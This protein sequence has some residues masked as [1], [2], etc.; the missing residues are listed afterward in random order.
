MSDLLKHITE[1]K[2]DGRI[3]EQ[4]ERGY[5]LLANW[6]DAIDEGCQGSRPRNIT[7]NSPANRKDRRPPKK[8]KP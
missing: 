4:R 3:T 1:L 2:E 5:K 7:D 8:N 6:F